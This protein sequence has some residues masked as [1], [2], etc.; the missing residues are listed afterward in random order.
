MSPGASS[1][2]L[3]RL[4]GDLSQCKGLDGAAH[5]P[6]KPGSSLKGGVSNLELVF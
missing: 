6:P 2:R 1:D 5:T 3:V 4:N